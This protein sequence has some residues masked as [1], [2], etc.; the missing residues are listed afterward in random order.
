[1]KTKIGR[2]GALGAIDIELFDLA[3]AVG[4]A[5]RRADAGARGLAV[6]D[7]ARGDL[8][9]ERRVEA[10]IIRRIELDLV[11][12]HEDQRTLL[13]LGG[14]MWHSAAS[15]GVAASVAAAPSMARRLICLR[16]FE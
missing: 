6:G 8:P 16:V 12:V 4:H 9:C 11:V 7:I 13:M 15:A 10:L 3:R 1:M 5:L 14:P 2:V